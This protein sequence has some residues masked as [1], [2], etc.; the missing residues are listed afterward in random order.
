M[1]IQESERSSG[2]RHCNITFIWQFRAIVYI[3]LF[4]FSMKIQGSKKSSGSRHCNITFIWQFS[5]P[6]FLCISY[7]ATSYLCDGFPHTFST[8]SKKMSVIIPNK[9]ER[10]DDCIFLHLGKR[11]TISVTT[12]ELLLVITSLATMTLPLNYPYLLAKRLP[13]AADLSSLNIDSMELPFIGRGMV[14]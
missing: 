5:K 1:K 7:K 12:L 9:I 2:S 8:F 3:S 14:K 11:G 10:S 4:L 6:C 13:P